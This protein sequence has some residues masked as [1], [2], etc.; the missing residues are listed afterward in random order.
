MAVFVT[1]HWTD[2]T[3][4]NIALHKE[5]RRILITQSSDFILRNLFIHSDVTLMY[6]TGE[7]I[8]SYC[9]LLCHLYHFS[10]NKSQ[11]PLVNQIVL[12]YLNTGPTVGT[13]N[14]SRVI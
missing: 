1:L 4:H 9:C 7:M 3:G 11:Q 12:F 6:P 14:A 13:R 2:K 10:L 5:Q 8:S